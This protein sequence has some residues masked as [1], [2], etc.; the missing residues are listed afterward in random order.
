MGGGGGQWRSQ[1]RVVA[2]AQVG[3]H[4]PYSGKFSLVQIFE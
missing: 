1:N 4:I 2:R 3:Q